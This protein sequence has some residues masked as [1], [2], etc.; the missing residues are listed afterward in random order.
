MQQFEEKQLRLSEQKRD[1]WL[2]MFYDA[3]SPQRMDYD[4]GINSLPC[5]QGA[6]ARKHAPSIALSGRS[7]TAFSGT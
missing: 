7:R 2:L 6:G 4:Q 5:R 3:A 1:G